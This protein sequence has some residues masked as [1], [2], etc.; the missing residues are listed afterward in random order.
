MRQDENLAFLLT[1][2]LAIKL[3][4]Q[5]N[6]SFCR[7]HH[8]K[9][10]LQILSR[11]YGPIVSLKLGSRAPVIVSSVSASEEY[12]FIKNESIFSQQA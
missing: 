4:F 2:S 11:Q 10:S 6:S 7:N 1:T 8:C 12:C 9:K 5:R 3:V